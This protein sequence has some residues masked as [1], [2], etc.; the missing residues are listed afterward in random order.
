MVTDVDAVDQQRNEIK[1]V[2]RRALPGRKLRR[3]PRDEAAAD[4]ALAGTP[5]RHRR[6]ERLQAAGV[7]PGGHADEHLLDD[8]TIEWI[9]RGH[10]LKR[11]QSG[12]YDSS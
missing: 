7:L 9:G 5:A 6:T 2:E 1:A 11:R 10:C 8:P 12:V 4:D 3:C